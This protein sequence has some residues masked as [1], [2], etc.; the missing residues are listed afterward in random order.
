MQ[1]NIFRGLVVKD[2]GGIGGLKTVS[3]RSLGANQT[4]V[5]YNGIV[6]TE[7]Q[8]GQIDLG[9][10]SL[11]NI[12]SLGLYNSN[13]GIFMPAKSF[14][15]GSLLQLQSGMDKGKLRQLFYKASLKQGSFGFINPAAKISYKWNNHLYTSLNAEWQRA[16]GE[17]PFTSYENDGEKRKRINSD[18][19]TYRSE[20]DIS[21][22]FSDS[23]RISLKAYYYN[24]ERGLPGAI[25]LNNT[26]IGRERLWDKN[27]FVQASWLKNFSAK[28][29]LM[30]NAKY[31]YIRNRYLNPDYFNAQGRLENIFS[32]NE[33]YQSAVYC[34]TPFTWLSFSY[35]ADYYINNLHRTDQFVVNFPEPVRKTLLNNIAARFATKKI[36]IEA[37]ILRSI[38]K[39]KTSFG[40]S[41]KDYD[42]LTPAFALSWQPM[43]SVPV[44]LR[45]FY[46]NIFRIPT[47]NDLYYTY[48]GNTNL[49]PEFAKQYNAGLTWQQNTTG[50]IQAAAITADGYINRVTDKIVA[51]PRQNLF[52]W[53]MQNI[54]K[55]NIQGI[56]AGIK[57][58][59]REVHKITATLRCTYTYQHAVDVT[60]KTSA[61]Y[62][63][64]IP[65]TPLHSGS[66]VAHFTY[67]KCSFNY[68]VLLSGNRYKTG[69]N[70]IYNRVDGYT[71]HDASFSFKSS[72]KNIE[73]T[74]TTELNNVFNKQY[75]VIQYYPM[76]GTNYRVGIIL[77][78]K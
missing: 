10:L 13:P 51:V 23:N 54:G 18:I 53:S 66:A 2:Y 46:K 25:I 58:F 55:V 37:N 73:Y 52:Q 16:K 62:N 22:L 6:L 43:E 78:N 42:K 48:I 28:S 63:N 24:A 40:P 14:A 7:A 65:Y 61:L 21:Y 11:D 30:V 72:H 1:S 29:K 67:K 9:K 27:F 41:G 34:Y 77:N 5:A 60:D 31:N 17:Y 69:E 50:I 71:I 70:N 59:C 12:E 44:R 64:Q 68:S 19:H 4:G 47:F 75:E 33:I 39:E 3:V 35:A 32:Q 76:P 49:R 20:L 15:Y 26:A 74:L 38:T 56:D 36:E 57:I 8:G 45:A